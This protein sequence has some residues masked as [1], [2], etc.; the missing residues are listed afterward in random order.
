MTP[1]PGNATARTRVRHDPPGN[2][3][4]FK[5][6][7]GQA[8]LL[9]TMRR[10]TSRQFRTQC[11]ASGW[12]PAR[13]TKMRKWR[14]GGRQVKLRSISKLGPPPAGRHSGPRSFLEIVLAQDDLSLPDGKNP[15]I[16]S[17][18]PLPPRALGQ[19][20]RFQPFPIHPGCKPPEGAQIPFSAHTARMH[21]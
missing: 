14:G 16:H 15:R 5:K 2:T 21:K 13:R 19:A 20:S 3:K 17:N 7:S 12:G 9:R 10:G 11:W 8:M 4:V 18:H 6:C 1:P